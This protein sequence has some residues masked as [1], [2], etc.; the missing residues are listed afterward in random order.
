MFVE[1][2]KKGRAWYTRLESHQLTD[3]GYTVQNKAFISYQEGELG[4]PA[5]LTSVDEWADLEESFVLGYQNG[6]TLERPLFVYFKMPFANHIDAESP[7]GVS[8]CARAAGLMEQADRQYSRI[9]WEF[10][11]SELAID[12][13]AMALKDTKLPKGKERLF[14][15]IGVQK[16]NGDELYNV[17]S[18][19]IRDAS[20]FNGLNQLLRR[21]EFN[22]N[23]SYGTLSDPQNQEKTAEEIR[24]QQAAQLCGG[25][26]YPEVLTDGVGAS[27]SG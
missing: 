10:E 20:L 23:L 4:V 22:C 12:A 2:V 1:R 13:D 19:A 21:I 15:K 26:Q 16:H 6:D 11:G 7:L 18:P 17:F 27:W 25:L 14:R 9:L 3:V 5:A 24:M 8:V